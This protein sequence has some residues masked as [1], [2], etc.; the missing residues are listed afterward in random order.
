MATLV[1]AIDLLKE[2]GMLKANEREVVID[3]MVA[4]RD[5]CI[6]KESGW[7]SSGTCLCKIVGLVLVSAS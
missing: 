7:I 5:G 2:A 3:G 4:A 1:E 6:T